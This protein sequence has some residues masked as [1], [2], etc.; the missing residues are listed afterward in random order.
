MPFARSTRTS[1]RPRTTTNSG[2]TVSPWRI[3]SATRRDRAPVHARSTSARRSGG[4]GAK[5]APSIGSLAAGCRTGQSRAGGDLVRRC[6]RASRASPCIPRS[7]LV[8]VLVRDRLDGASSFASWRASSSV[9]GRVSSSAVDVVARR[10]AAAAT[11]RRCGEARRASDRRRAY[12]TGSGSGVGARAR[13]DRR[14]ER[15]PSVGGASTSAG[16]RIVGGRLGSIERRQRGRGVGLDGDG[17]AA[18]SASSA[19]QRDVVGRDLEDAAAHRDRLLR[20]GPDR[21]TR[22]RRERYSSTASAARP[23]SRSAPAT[24]TRSA[25]LSGS[26]REPLLELLELQRHDG[27]SDTWALNVIAGE[28]CGSAHLLATV[29]MQLSNVSPS[30]GANDESLVRARAARSSPSTVSV[31]VVRLQAGVLLERLLVALL[32]RAARLR[33]DVEELLATRPPRPCR[34]TGG[35]PPPACPA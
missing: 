21:D 6:P 23:A 29:L 30:D 27:V 9:T 31:I 34:S 24:V 35:G 10:R 26:C 33:D 1:S 25:R 28:F 19:W 17:L 4:S 8:G 18:S 2:C 22:S 20:R 7:V 11:V 12:G 3:T 13:Y 32:D 14:A 5:N 15:R 16:S